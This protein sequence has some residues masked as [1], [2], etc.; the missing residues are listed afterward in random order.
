MF[1]MG[2]NHVDPTAA[3]SAC[4]DAR[5]SVYFS[6]G[7]VHEQHGRRV[8]RVLHDQLPGAS[9]QGA[10]SSDRTCVLGHFAS[11][12]SPT[13]CSA[14]RHPSSPCGLVVYPRRGQLECTAAHGSES[15]TLSVLVAGLALRRSGTRGHSRETIRFAN[16]R[17][18][19]WSNPHTSAH[20][21]APALLNE[22]RQPRPA[23]RPSHGL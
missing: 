13:V 6:T 12:A 1:V 3:T 11:L 16:P 18:P 4:S 7:E 17:C 19:R 2:V 22:H 14:S 8:Q 9:R 20:L 10:L 15:R 21:S 23:R 5:S